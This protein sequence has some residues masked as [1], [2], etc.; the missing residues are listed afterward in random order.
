MEGVP[1][2]LYSFLT[3]M[4]LYYIYVV[5]Q[6]S[7]PALTNWGCVLIFSVQFSSF[8]SESAS[9]EFLDKVKKNKGKFG[10]TMLLLHPS[11]QLTII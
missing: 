1:H 9:Y 5:S 8:P 11:K 4:S 3:S 7:Q 10:T 2:W 6:L